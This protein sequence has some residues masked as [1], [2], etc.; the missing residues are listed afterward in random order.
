[1]FTFYI[2]PGHGWLAV[3]V[4]DLRALDL[5]AVDFTKYSHVSGDGAVFF[6]EEDCD[7]PKFINAYRARHGQEPVIRE[8]QAFNIRRLPRN[9]A[10]MWKP[11]ARQS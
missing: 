6:L 9:A 10:G 3:R 2:D 7:A 1:M 4:Q 5:S 11:F 8:R